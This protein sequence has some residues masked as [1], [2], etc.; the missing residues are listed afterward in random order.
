MLFG[1]RKEWGSD[2]HYNMDRP[3]KHAKWNKA[4]ATRQTVYDAT[5]KKHLD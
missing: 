1:H 5:Y 4:D 3:S 2:I